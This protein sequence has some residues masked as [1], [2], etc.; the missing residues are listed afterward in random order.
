MNYKTSGKVTQGKKIGRTLGFPTANITLREE[1]EIE[2]G[3]YAAKITTEGTTYKAMVSVGI[4]P[5]V[6]ENL[7]RR[8]EAYLFD[9]NGDLYDKIIE[10][11]LVE[12]IRPEE[13]FPSLEA[14]KSKIEC[15]RIEILNFFKNNPH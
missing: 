1:E 5:T 3:V 15:D 13:K 4:R 6:G 10:V 7:D 8:L 2:N 14:L 9:F 12:F 11:E